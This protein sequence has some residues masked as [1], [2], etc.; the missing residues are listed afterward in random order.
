MHSKF[1]SDKEKYV[2][3]LVNIVSHLSDDRQIEMNKWNR[4]TVDTLLQLGMHCTM[5]KFKRLSSAIEVKSITFWCKNTLSILKSV[6]YLRHICMPKSVNQIGA[7]I[8]LFNDAIKLFFSYATDS[9][10][11]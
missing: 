6:L 7:M 5:E 3:E 9:M 10:S 2:Q 11:L 4:I 1:N 8:N